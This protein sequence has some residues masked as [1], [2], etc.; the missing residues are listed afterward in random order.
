MLA[1]LYPAL[2]VVTALPRVL[3]GPAATSQW[4]ES[5]S[6]NGRPHV[7]LL[8]HSGRRQLT[9]VPHARSGSDDLQRTVTQL[10]YSACESATIFTFD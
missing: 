3:A 6:P 4:P 2:V 7:R 5:T 9:H 1:I 10:A 8:R